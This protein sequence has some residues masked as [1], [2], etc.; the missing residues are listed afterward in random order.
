MLR[1]VANFG[2]IACTVLKLFHYY[3]QKRRYVS[4]NET[5]HLACFSIIC[6][7]L[8]EGE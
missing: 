1:R 2:V 7:L 3:V 8:I 5:F 4:R 6:I